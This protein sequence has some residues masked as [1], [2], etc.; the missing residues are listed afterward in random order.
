MT[1]HKNTTD[2]IFSITRNT[3]VAL[4]RPKWIFDKLMSL[5][6]R[7]T[8]L[9][10]YE[11]YSLYDIIIGFPYLSACTT[12]PYNN[13]DLFVYEVVSIIWFKKLTPFVSMPAC[14]LL[15][16]IYK[17]LKKKGK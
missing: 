16:F 12:T 3:D 11:P 6:T 14:Y 10:I 17:E 9:G 13:N 8:N 1:N 15:H 4:M 2:G 5:C 7:D